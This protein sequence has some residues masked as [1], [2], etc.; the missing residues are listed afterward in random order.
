MNPLV[1]YAE[2]K[3]S[4]EAAIGA[5]DDLLHLHAGLLILVVAT[6]LF[7]RGVGSRLP[8]A[9]VYLLALVNESMDAL[10]ASPEARGW[11]PA[12]DVANTVLW[13][14]LLFCLAR[15]H[16]RAIRPVKPGSEEY[17]REKYLR[18]QT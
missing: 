3:R 13:P 16:R 18:G 14:T 11:E 8:I 12:V 17:F 2:T 6:V 10:C 9:M 4:L 5:S 15:R 7:G 1:L